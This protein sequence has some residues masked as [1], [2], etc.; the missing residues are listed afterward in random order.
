MTSIRIQGVVVA[1]R[2]VA[3]AKLNTID[4]KSQ[5]WTELVIERATW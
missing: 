1:T 4:E 5:C 2:I 3:N